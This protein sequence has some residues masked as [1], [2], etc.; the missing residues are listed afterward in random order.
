MELARTEKR[1]RMKKLEDMS[2]HE[3]WELRVQ[4]LR[5]R[6]HERDFDRNQGLIAMSDQVTKEIGR[7]IHHDTL[8]RLSIKA[9]GNQMDPRS[10][11]S[12][13]C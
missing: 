9:N 6:I 8:Q 10:G 7:R 3:L 1:K 12:R 2:I 13:T 4:I 11:H 5:A